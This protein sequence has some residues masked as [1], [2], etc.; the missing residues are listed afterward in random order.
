MTLWV[1]WRLNESPNC[2]A[3]SLA[4]FWLG[5]GGE[6]L[7]PAEALHLAESFLEPAPIRNGVLQPLILLLG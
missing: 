6:E 2:F 5:Q 3:E 7:L 4:A 1:E